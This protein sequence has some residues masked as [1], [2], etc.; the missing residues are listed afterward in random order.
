MIELVGL[1]RNKGALF[2]THKN[3]GKVQHLNHSPHAAL[4]IWLP[5]TLRQV[6]IDGEVVEISAAEAEKSWKRMPR[7]M[8][9]TFMASDH[10]G[11]ITSNEVLDERKN[12]LEKLY[13]KEIPMPDTFIGYRIFPKTV[14]FYEM[15]PRNFPVKRVAHLEQGEWTI[16]QVEP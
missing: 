10:Q 3:T 12:K 7:F 11:E 4:N 5:Q 15:K 8:K 9:I 2:F 16:C 14:V 13:S 1:S 6:S